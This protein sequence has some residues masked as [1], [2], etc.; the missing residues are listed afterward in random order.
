M[1]HDEL[2]L[3]SFKR[4]PEQKNDP[5]NTPTSLIVVCCNKFGTSKPPARNSFSCQLPIAEKCEPLGA[6]LPC[7]IQYSK[8]CFYSRSR[9]ARLPYS[10][11]FL[12]VGSLEVLKG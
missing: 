5:E 3:Q 9:L 4:D 1:G 11:H 6:V 8:S 7:S 12:Q 10:E 2:Y